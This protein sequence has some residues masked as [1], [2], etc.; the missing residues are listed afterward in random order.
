[1]TNQGAHIVKHA[2][3]TT[4]GTGCDAAELALINAH[5]IKE[6]TADEVFVFSV[7]L[8]DNEVDRDGE[9]FDIPTLHALAPLFTGKSGVF[10]HNATAKNQTARIFECEV[11]CDD[12]RV[13][14]A[15]ERYHS[16]KARAY[17]LRGEK[18]QSL[19]SEI[20]AGIKKEVSVG[21]AVKQ[22]LCS[23][24]GCDVRRSPCEHR[25]GENTPNGVVCHRI[26]S[27]ALDA[28]EWS[29]VAVPAQIAAGVTKAMGSGVSDID[30]ILKRLGGEPIGCEEGERLRGYIQTIVELAACGRAYREELEDEVVRLM[31]AKNVEADCAVLK[32]A[33]QGI[34]VAALRELRALFVCGQENY[35]AAASQL[36]TE[37]KMA[38]GSANTEFRI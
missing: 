9:R 2:A 31:Y 16:L 18:T 20:E 14:I 24:C 6:L 3:Q 27:G 34:S 30:S 32:A 1:M 29:F 21:C 17:M 5:A 33:V 28:Y 13:T 8:C 7:T 19:I 36:Y 11:I 22:V 37:E 25:T 12:G 38:K 23:V 15:G 35:L 10:D 4:K 26:L